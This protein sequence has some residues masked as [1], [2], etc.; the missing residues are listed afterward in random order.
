MGDYNGD[1][2]EKAGVVLRGG[3]AV[4]ATAFADYDNDGRI[5]LF[6]AAEDDSHRFQAGD[7]GMLREAAVPGLARETRVRKAGAALIVDLIE[8]VRGLQ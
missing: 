2:A 8:V 7:G 4:L 6:V 1:Q 5:D 3:N